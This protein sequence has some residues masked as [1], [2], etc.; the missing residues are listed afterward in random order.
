M[1]AQIFFYSILFGLG[2]HESC[3]CHQRIQAIAGHVLQY[4]V[5]TPQVDPMLRTK[6]CSAPCTGDLQNQI[7]LA[8]SAEMKT[9]TCK[10]RHQG[11]SKAQLSSA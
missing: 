7:Q 10:A 1:T 11:M 6:A 4:L 5:Y 3:G 9:L 2:T 8:F